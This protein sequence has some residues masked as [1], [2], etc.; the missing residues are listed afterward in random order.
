MEKL[1][2]R[3]SLAR[4]LKEQRAEGDPV[5][6]REVLETERESPEYQ[7]RHDELLEARAQVEKSEKKERTKDIDETVAREPGS[8]M[9][10][11]TFGS[12]VHA[13]IVSKRIWGG[14]YFGPDGAIVAG[15]K[16]FEEEE[17]RGEPTAAYSGRSSLYYSAAGNVIAHKR[18]SQLPR[19]T[20]LLFKAYVDSNNAVSSAGGLEGMGIGQ[21]HVR[22]SIVRKLGF[23]GSAL[24][25]MNE[26]LSRAD[27]PAHARALLLIDR[28]RLSPDDR[29]RVK[30]DLDEVTRELLPRVRA[31][32][33][34]K[35]AARVARGAAEI[36]R[37]LQ[38]S[39]SSATEFAALRD[40]AADLEK[41]AQE[42]AHV[43]SAD[44]AVK[45]TAVNRRWRW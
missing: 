24:R 17:K 9:A 22:E 33:N 18:V 45:A 34:E 32:G 19:A 21:L 36:A 30:R 2:Y 15:E 14:E 13:A 38:Q 42:S 3:D 25:C 7:K 11:R 35:D 37:R 23:S 26:A 20:L 44:Q 16:R 8:E 40:L 29:E 4:R 43:S 41:Q 10:E 5:A 31:E 12:R 1:G 28:C 6:A 27:V 39:N